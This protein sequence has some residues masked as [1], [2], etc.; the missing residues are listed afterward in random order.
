MREETLWSMHGNYSDLSNNASLLGKAP[1]IRNLE[2]RAAWSLNILWI[3]AHSSLQGN[4]K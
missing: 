3:E 4:L 2:N 1:V